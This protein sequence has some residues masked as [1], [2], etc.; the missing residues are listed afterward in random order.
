MY[1]DSKSCSLLTLLLDN[2]KNVRLIIYIIY[3]IVLLTSCNKEESYDFPGDT[4]NR[5]YVRP[6]TGDGFVFMH[7]PVLSMSSLNYKMPV[8]VTRVSNEDITVSLAVD[9]SLVELYN[10]VNNTEYEAVPDDVLVLENNKVIIPKGSYQ[11]LDSICISANENMISNLRN[12]KGYLIPIRIMNVEGNGVACSSNLDCVYLIVNTDNRS[13]IINKDAKDTD[14]SGTL[15]VN[16]RINWNAYLDDAGEVELT[17][18]IPSMFDGDMSTELAISSSNPF[19]FVIDM[20]N[21]YDV[22]AIY[23]R[24]LYYGRVEQSTFSEGFE[25][26]YS[27]D[28]AE[29]K[30]LGTVSASVGGYF[31]EKNIIFYAAVPMRYIRILSPV[32]SSYTGDKASLNIGEF[33]VYVK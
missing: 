26:E 6:Y 23:S 1:S 3:S 9:N 24:Y 19:Y 11:S 13:E 15:V 7:T 31:G 8:Y 14:V 18:E 12:E 2:M 20:Q 30:T 32:K 25:L 10:M 33:N 29:W 4:V 5:V 22:T 21:V 17:G 28:K 16:G 27:L